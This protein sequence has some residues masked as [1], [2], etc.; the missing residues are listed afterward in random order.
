MVTLQG[1]ATT[2]RT[3]RNIEALR[4][5]GW[6]LLLS[7]DI[8]NDW[9]MRYGLDNGAWGCF[10]QGRAFDDVAFMRLL[11]SKGPGADWVVVPDI[12]AGGLKSL[13]FSL[14]WLPICQRHACLCLLAVQDGMSPKDVVDHL[15]PG[16]GL[17]VGGST[18]YKLKTLAEWGDVAAFFECYLHVG[19]VN[20]QR[21]IR[22]CKE[23]GADSFDGTSATRYSTTL[24]LLNAE[25][26]QMHFWW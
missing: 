26:T 25:L 22:L 15:R 18:E 19:R 21:R 11:K 9:G 8:Q 12:V 13:S 20:T 5:S 1:Y 3:K 6:R 10:Q 17:F 24:R 23:A 2:T 7:P 16:I 4:R 14:E